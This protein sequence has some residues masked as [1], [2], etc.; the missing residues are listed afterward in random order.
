MKKNNTIS[1][2]RKL[3]LLRACARALKK[4]NI[5]NR[6]QKSREMEKIKN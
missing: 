1:D 5:Q 6:E 3:V 4:I 2:K